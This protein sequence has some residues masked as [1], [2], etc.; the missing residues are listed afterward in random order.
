MVAIAS[1]YRIRSV[2]ELGAGR[3]STPTLLNRAAF[4][5]LERLDSLE[6]DSEW[7]KTVKELAGRDP[8]LDL[9]LV[10]GPISAAVANLD[11]S[12]YDAVLVDDSTRLEDRVETIKGVAARTGS[13]TIVLIHDYEVADYRRASARFRNRYAFTAFTPQ[14]GALWNGSLLGRW[15]MVWLN[16]RIKFMARR[17]DPGDVRGWV[18]SFHGR[19]KAGRGPS[20]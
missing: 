16:S 19:Q 9:K 2:L 4:A 13:S 18:T 15:T 10:D 14:T 8:R 6:N 5:D 1:R 7:A 3:F 11:F 12:A 17:L 20:A